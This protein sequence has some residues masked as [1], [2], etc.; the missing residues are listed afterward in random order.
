MKGMTGA[1]L[2]LRALRALRSGCLSA[3]SSRALLPMGSVFL[4]TSCVLYPP[5]RSSPVRALQLRPVLCAGHN[6]W[7]KVKNIKGPKD[8]A[9]ARIF[10]KFAMMIK[11]AVKG[12]LGS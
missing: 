9:R 4:P 6:K 8:E 7:S 11:I 10:T 12:E 2:V 3:S 1:A 5:W